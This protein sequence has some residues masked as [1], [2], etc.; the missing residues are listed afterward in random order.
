VDEKR[1]G[2][3][4]AFYS[5]KGGVGR[6]LVLANVAWILASNDKRVLV[7]DWDLEA[8]GLEEYFRACVQPGLVRRTAGVIDLLEDYRSFAEA[9]LA[10]RAG[11]RHV[12]ST[13]SGEDPGED[14]LVPDDRDP[15]D[16]AYLGDN[17]IG[18][19]L[20]AGAEGCV[21]LMPAGRRAK[22]YR[23][24][25]YSTK[26]TGFDWSRFYTELD[27]GE[28]L[29]ALATN[30]RDEYDYVLVDSRTG[31]S[32]VAAVGPLKLAD[33]V[34]NCFGMSEQSIDGALKISEHIEAVR[35]PGSVTVYPVPMR[36][37]RRRADMASSAR[38]HYER[39]FNSQLPREAKD[40]AAY[41]N[42]VE[43]PYQ[44][45]YAFEETVAAASGLPA[46]ATDDFLR[47]CENL[48][49]YITDKDV[50]G[51]GAI[52]EEERRR[53][54][55]ATR[56]KRDASFGRVVVSYAH[57]DSRW[58]EWVAW[59][60]TR[61]G[62]EVSRH[63]AA[64]EPARNLLDSMWGRAGEQPLCVVAVLS[65]SYG[66]TAEGATVWEWA[67]GRLTA[68]G[69]RCLLPVRVSAEKIPELFREVPALDLF[70]LDTDVARD[71]IAEL[72]GP[73]LRVAEQRTPPV[74]VP[75]F[76][77]DTVS[78][79]QRFAQRL[80]R[81]RQRADDRGIVNNAVRLGELYAEDGQI[82]KARSLFEEA[83]H[84]TGERN[85]DLGVRPRRSLGLLEREHG[86]ADRAVAQLK[87]A[88]KLVGAG[89]DERTA[90]LLDLAETYR[91]A[92]AGD[93]RERLT[94]A[95]EFAGEAKRAAGG[96]PRLRGRALAQIGL[97]EEQRGEHKQARRSF[98]NARH[99]LD[100]NARHGLVLDADDDIRIALV[101]CA[102]G[103]VAEKTGDSDA[104]SK[105][106]E[107]AYHMVGLL[108]EPE[109]W[110]PVHE[111]L[112]SCA[113][114]FTRRE[115]PGRARELYL[116]ALGLTGTNGRRDPHRFF[117]T[118]YRLGEITR[119]IEVTAPDTG[120]GNTGGGQQEGGD[121]TQAV[122]KESLDYFMDAVEGAKRAGLGPSERYADALT[123]VRDRILEVDG[124]EAALENIVRACWVHLGIGDEAGAED[125]R[126]W[127]AAHRGDWCDR[128]L[129]SFARNTFPPDEARRL[130]AF[131]REGTQPGEAK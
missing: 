65:P 95:D 49:G 47:Q 38:H 120:S 69:D 19:A 70:E 56:R 88:L 46:G 126:R 58:A 83:V 3:I 81:A 15:A 44:I 34:V 125:D 90:I 5:F 73:S 35:E 32:E 12:P 112:S 71:K 21:D 31:I 51:L 39:A 130:L 103:R 124:L 117:D 14:P 24:K 63:A 25:D 16:Y 45:D 105:Y 101:D 98:L 116:R 129:E 107:A 118:N 104:A 82:E 41:W 6:S 1:A 59:C 86:D 84:L 9:R 2:R 121:R 68:D 110:R 54:H 102:L 75:P 62:F 106:F 30:M 115:S 23:A 91:R 114:F 48:T 108:A 131:L 78:Q 61:Q 97:I 33:V 13:D 11:G 29:Q 80:G 113:D 123:A 55:E 109:E 127:F 4:I 87:A 7:V 53:F 52:P 18:L 76:P 40:P 10:E 57:Q 43:I 94:K 92:G 93:S 28:F 20:W 89:T 27:G 36:V 119:T 96:N 8:P 111:V 85:R 17:V 122:A 37:D 79:V 77:G 26:V 67:K 100:V 128:H 50:L 60:A 22:D 72:L 74:A 66:K 64:D 42:E 99:A